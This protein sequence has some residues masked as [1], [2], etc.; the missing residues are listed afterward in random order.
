[1][2]GLDLMMTALGNPSMT[3]LL[4]MMQERMPNNE[5]MQQA[6]NEITSEITGSLA[7]S[8]TEFKVGV[9]KYLKD[10]SV[11]DRIKKHYDISEKPIVEKDTLEIPKVVGVDYDGSTNT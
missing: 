8:M 3:K 10:P 6:V 1:M 7:D 11:V 2:Q 9:D 5:I 4:G